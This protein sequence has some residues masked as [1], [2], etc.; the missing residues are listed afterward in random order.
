MSD[1]KLILHIGSTK[2]G[3]KSI[4]RAL[5]SA[6][7]GGQRNWI[8]PRAGRKTSAHHNLAYEMGAAFRTAGRWKL[9]QGGWDA[10][11]AEAGEPA[12]IIISSEAFIYLTQPEIAT[13]ADRIGHLNPRIQLYLRRLDRWAHSHCIQ[14]LR[15]GRADI[16][17]PI[18]VVNTDM[19]QMWGQ[20]GRAQ[21]RIV[22][23][24][25]H[26][27]GHDAVTVTAFDR[28]VIGDDIVQHFAKA[29]D[30]RDHDDWPDRVRAHDSPSLKTLLAVWKLR[31]LCAE[32]LGAD[33]ALTRRMA[34]LV[35][36]HFRDRGDVVPRYQLLSA[37]ACHAL[38]AAY[39][40]D[41]AQLKALLGADA[42]VF[43]SLD[44]LD[45]ADYVARPLDY[46]DA[47]SDDEMGFVHDLAQRRIKMG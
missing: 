44:D 23:D 15:F 18:D 22:A 7:Q 27:F 38:W 43:A 2:T 11:L 1:T 32:A 41:Q 46:L 13:L 29:H 12:R 24:W 6:P 31:T 25:V 42:P 33:F 5:A 45:D 10:A 19:F 21:G 17:T 3:T 36:S 40:D 14:Q 35:S 20:D 28:S 30:L 8:Y 9:D 37:A 34:E 4:Q 26:V 47:F 16:G 39:R